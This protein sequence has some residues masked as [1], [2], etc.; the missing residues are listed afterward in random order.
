[1]KLWEISRV[2]PPLWY[3]LKKVWGLPFSANL[4]SV[5]TFGCLGGLSEAAWLGVRQDIYI[6]P[7][8]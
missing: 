3:K 6:S 7:T 5:P 1:M 4:P 2:I 8:S